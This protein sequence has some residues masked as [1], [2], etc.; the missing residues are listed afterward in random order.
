MLGCAIRRLGIGFGLLALGWWGLAIEAGAAAA[1]A[2]AGVAGLRDGGLSA[3]D[4]LRF[5]AKMEG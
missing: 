4:I 2:A 1:A 3:M 5:F